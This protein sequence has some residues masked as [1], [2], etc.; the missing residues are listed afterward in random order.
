MSRLLQKYS[1]LPKGVKASGWFFV[2]SLLQ[3]GISVITTP[4]FTRLLSTEEYGIYNVF[5]SWEGI[6]AIILTLKLTGGTYQQAIV[7]NRNSR[8]Q[9]ASSL[10]GLTCVIATVGL[11]VVGVSRNWIEDVLGVPYQLVGLLIISTVMCAAFEF[12]AQIQ[13]VEYNYRPLVLV[14]IFVILAKPIISIIAI[15]ATEHF[16]VYARITSILGVEIL[17]YFGIFALVF[18][19]GKCFYNKSIWK[20]GLKLSIPLLPHYL[21]QSILSSSDR[22]MLN[23][24]AGASEAG[25]YGLAYQV[26]MIMTMV[27]V[28]LRDT[29]NPWILKKI[30]ENKTEEIGGLCYRLLS[31]V[32]VANIVLIL[33]APEAVL[34]FAPSDYYQAIWVIPPVAM[35][36][37]FMF[38]YN[39]FVNFEFYYEKNSRIMMATVVSA[40]TNILLNAWLIPKYGSVAAAC[41]TLVSYIVYCIAHYITYKAIEKKH[42]GIKIYN[43]KTIILISGVFMV[44]GFFVMSLYRMP[45]IRYGMVSIIGILLVIKRKT[46]MEV[47]MIKKRIKVKDNQ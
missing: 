31:V 35:S 46:V 20:Y 30:N 16:K 36:V 23:K 38:L 25:I 5:F 26:S 13:R 39:I 37:Y 14:T 22:I 42:Y 40:V 32:A 24:L 21:A 2:C 9:Y 43:I 3:K 28:A 12:W 1:S 11:V 6:F 10:L 27:N 44:V 19:R 45:Y 33:T 18:F 8:D 4:I 47:F 41:T 15:K 17:A 7:K 34:F 29:L